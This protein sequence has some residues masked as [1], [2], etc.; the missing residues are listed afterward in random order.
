MRCIWCGTKYSK[1]FEE[2]S[3]GFCSHSCVKKWEGSFEVLCKHLSVDEKI[4][5]DTPDLK[6]VAG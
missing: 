1:E 3:A 2:I 6:Y 5:L 4:T